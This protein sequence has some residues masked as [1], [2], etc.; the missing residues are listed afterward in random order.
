MLHT[1]TASIFGRDCLTR[2][3]GLLVLSDWTNPED[4]ATIREASR[5]IVD[6]AETVAKQNG[7]FLRFKYLNYASRDQDPLAGY[8]EENVRRLKDVARRVDP[9]GVFQRLQFG[10]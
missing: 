10:G 9:G 1:Y 8:G 2:I 5:K 7:T 3:T 6:R 4:E